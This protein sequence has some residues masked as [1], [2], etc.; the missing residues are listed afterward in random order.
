MV[1]KFMSGWGAAEGKRNLLAIECDSLPKAEAIEAAAKRRNEMKYV[2][3]VE[4][5]RARANDLITMRKFDD[6]NGPW[7][8]FYNPNNEWTP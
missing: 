4:R 5:I 8:Q 2:R 1:D 6:M 3:I 7:K